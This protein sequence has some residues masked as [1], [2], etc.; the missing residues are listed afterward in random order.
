[1]RCVICWRTQLLAAQRTHLKRAGVEGPDQKGL[2]LA[3]NS[4]DCSDCPRRFLLYDL[5][6]LVALARFKPS[7]NPVHPTPVL[8]FDRVSA[9]NEGKASDKF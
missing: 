9:I 5:A 6:W 1:M 7:M 3:L 8:H 2:F 4:L